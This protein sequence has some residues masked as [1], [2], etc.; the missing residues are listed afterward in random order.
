MICPRTGLL[1]KSAYSRFLYFKL[2]TLV[3]F[4][5]AIIAITRYS[6]TIYWPLVY[7][8]ICLLHVG[9]VYSNKCPR[10]AYYNMSEGTHKCFMIWGF[11]KIF[12]ARP[13]PDKPFLGDQRQPF[14]RVNDNY[15]SRF[16]LFNESTMFFALPSL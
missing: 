8:G 9:I 10:C 1:T 3:P 2:V 13:G 4:L 5:T 6:E 14:F 7:I 11:P 16:E 15:F 12:E